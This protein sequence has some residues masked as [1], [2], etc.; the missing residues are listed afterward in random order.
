MDKFIFELAIQIK[1]GRE[2]S[3]FFICSELV[4]IRFKAKFRR[5]I[6]GFTSFDTKIILLNLSKLQFFAALIRDRIFFDKDNFETIVRSKFMKKT[7]VLS[8]ENSLVFLRFSVALIFLLH[9]VV[10]ILNSTIGRFGDFMESK[11]FPYG[12]AWVYGITAFEIIGGSLLML[13]YFTKILSAGFISLLVVGIILIH[14]GKGWF[15]GEH[16][17][18]GCEYSF[19]L[20]A[21]LTVI[22]ASKNLPYN[23]DVGTA[24]QKI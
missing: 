12:N 10:R 4:L 1:K 16:G 23:M 20:I 11:G 15:V 7:L 21:A 5:F 3:S 13:G 22:A 24:Q 6:I 14:A 2:F 9:A 8:L 18:G 19:I 17:T